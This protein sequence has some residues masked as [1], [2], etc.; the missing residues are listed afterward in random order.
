MANII[1]RERFESVANKV[2]REHRDVRSFDF[3]KGGVRLMV[4]SRSGRSS[5]QANLYYCDDDGNYL[6]RCKV[7]ESAYPYSNTPS[8]IADDLNRALR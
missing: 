4:C 1:T 5:W 6:D 8:F 7:I 2:L 3:F